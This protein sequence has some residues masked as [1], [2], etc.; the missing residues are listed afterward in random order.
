MLD[1]IRPEERKD[2]LI[3]CVAL[4]LAFTLVFIRGGWTPL[5]LVVVFVS[6][7]VTVGLGFILHELAHK[8]TAVRFGYRAAFRK[9]NQMLLVAVALAAL[10]GVVFA[11]PGA[12]MIYVPPGRE[13]TKEENGK[14]SVAGPVVNLVLGAVFLVV[15][16]TGAAFALWPLMVLGTM[17][18]SVN[19]MIAFF[20]LLPVS[21]L[22]GRKVIAWSPVVFAVVIVLALG[23]ILLS[24]DF[25]GS[26]SVLQ[27]MVS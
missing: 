2:L 19:G 26:L 24:L 5:F 16:L 20:N 17:G 22:D 8:F 11:A 12:T 7:A 6:S 13:M 15:L 23:M 27:S 14:I 21:I 9:D 3:A 25:G 18:L 1:L 10:V 4:S